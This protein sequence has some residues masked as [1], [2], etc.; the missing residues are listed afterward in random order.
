MGGSPGWDFGLMFCSSSR[1]SKV[2]TA[3]PSCSNNV[4]TKWM[5]KSTL[6]TGIANLSRLA[7][8]MGCCVYN[9]H[10]GFWCAIRV[11]ALLGNLKRDMVFYPISYHINVSLLEYAHQCIWLYGL[12]FVPSI[13]VWIIMWLKFYY[14]RMC[15]YH[16]I[17]Y[18]SLQCKKGYFLGGS[19][20]TYTSN[21]SSV[22]MNIFYYNI[23]RIGIF[24]YR[25]VRQTLFHDSGVRMAILR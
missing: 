8:L 23:V 11:W 15:I 13:Y 20:W 25:S 9:L 24:L 18:I 7:L 6:S 4:L 5:T 21:C 12:C 19:V 16:A 14:F 1:K 22:R 17:R 3:L 10:T 2:P